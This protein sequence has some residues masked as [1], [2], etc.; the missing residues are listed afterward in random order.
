MIATSGD[1]NPYQPPKAVLIEDLPGKSVELPSSTK[2]ALAYAVLMGVGWVFTSGRMIYQ[3]GVR[4]LVTDWVDAMWTIPDFLSRLG[5]VAGLLLA[6]SFA[7]A[8]RLA[9]VMLAS[10]TI[11][12]MIS[13]VR[14]AMFP[15][16]TLQIAESI[17]CVL[18]Y[19][20]MFNL[21]YRFTF[22]LPS[23]RYYG[24]VREEPPASETRSSET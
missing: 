8:F 18:F 17:F 6:R 2:W 1:E 20:G 22:G 24:M 15:D 13:F 14:F 4:S 10:T 5:L 21:F 7:W 3:L 19:Y 11:L 12:S 23:R 9:C 16:G